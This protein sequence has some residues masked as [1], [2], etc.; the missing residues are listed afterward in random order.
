MRMQPG[1]LIQLRKVTHT[2]APRGKGKARLLGILLEPPKFPTHGNFPK[3]YTVLTP[4]GVKTFEE[5][6]GEV[7]EPVPEADHEAR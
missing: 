6:D 5:A 2:G 7:F 3:R 4:R 1:D